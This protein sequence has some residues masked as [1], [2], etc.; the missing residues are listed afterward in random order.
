M[1]CRPGTPVHL[2]ESQPGSRISGAPLSR[3]TA[4]GTRVDEHG[5]AKTKHETDSVIRRRTAANQQRSRRA[6][7]VQ[8][9]HA[10]RALCAA[11][12]GHAGPHRFGRGAK[13]KSPRGHELPVL[14]RRRP[15][16]HGEAEAADVVRAAAPWGGLSAR[17]VRSTF[18]DVAR[19]AHANGGAPKTAWASLRSAHPTAQESSV[20]A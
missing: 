13:S 17:S 2:S 6:G 9:S 7:R 15:V 12:A 5:E 16:V 8:Q 1:R 19:E 4:S 18:F 3:C 14:R 20:S 11:D 10:A